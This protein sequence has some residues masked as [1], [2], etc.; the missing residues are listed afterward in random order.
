MY[1]GWG[2][3]R[4]GDELSLY[5]KATDVTHGA[6]RE[7]AYVGGIISRAVYRLD[8]FMSVDSPFEG[9]DFVAPAL[10][11]DGGGSSGAENRI[12]GS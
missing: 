8:G 10:I 2:L 4:H 6:Y 3:S 11:F 9:G 1:A 5:Y 7:R 12:H